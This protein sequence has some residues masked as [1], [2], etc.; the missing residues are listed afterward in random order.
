MM[1]GL[2]AGIVLSVITLQSHMVLYLVFSKTVSGSYLNVGTFSF[3]SWYS[4][5]NFWCIIFATLLCLFIY[6]SFAIFLHPLI[7]CSIVS[8]FSPHFLLL[9]LLL[10]ITRSRFLHGKLIIALPP[11]LK[12]PKNMDH[13]LS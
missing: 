8:P 7:T 4:D 10:L 11:C 5:A 2:F 9:L 1:S 3:I 6:S 12:D 13:A